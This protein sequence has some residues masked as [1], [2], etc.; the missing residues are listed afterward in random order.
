[1][2]VFFYALIA[3]IL[4]SS[5]HDPKLGRKIYTQH[6]KVCHGIKGNTNPFAAQVLDPS[7]RDFTSLESKSELTEKRMILSVNQGRPG[8]AMMPWKSILSSDEIRAVVR[9]IRKQLMKS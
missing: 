6:C 5:D 3:T 7:P 9:Y 4:S 1:M 2:N 8:T